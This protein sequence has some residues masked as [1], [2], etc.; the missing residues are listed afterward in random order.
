MGVPQASTDARCAPADLADDLRSLLGKRVLVVASQAEPPFCL[1]LQA[2]VIGIEEPVPERRLITLHFGASQ[3][4]SVSCEE[5]AGFSGCSQRQ[6]RR[7]HW[8]ELQ[9]ASGPTVVIEEI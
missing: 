6:G 4:L 8:I 1:T 9:I 3:S 5:S 7:A 2:R